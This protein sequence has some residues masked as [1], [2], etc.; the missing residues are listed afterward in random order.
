VIRESLFSFEESNLTDVFVKYAL[1]YRCR[2]IIRNN[3]VLFGG[4]PVDLHLV[5]SL[6]KILYC[7]FRS[8]IYLLVS[9]LGLKSLYFLSYAGF[10]LFNTVQII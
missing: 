1:L 3:F 4:L 8:K 5:L 7:L 10:L 2:C 9:Y 6:F